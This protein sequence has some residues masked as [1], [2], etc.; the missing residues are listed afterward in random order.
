MPTATATMGRTSCGAER[1]RLQP[2]GPGWADGR[3][4]GPRVDAVRVFDEEPDLL[5]GIDERGAELLRRRAAAPRVWV[6]SGPWS[7]PAAD[8]R[9]GAS[10]GLLVIE[11]LM[12]RTVELEGHR[13]PELV[14]AGDVLRPWDE[15]DG[16]VS[17]ATSWT[18]LE[19]TSLAVLDEQFTAIV[20]RWPSIMVQLLSRSTQ[21]S[22]SLA[23]HFAIAH[24]RHAELR[25]HMLFWHLADRWGRMTPRGVHLPLRLT[26]EI[27]AQLAC[28][29]RPTASSAVNQL[30]RSGELARQPDGT[31]LLTGSP[32]TPAA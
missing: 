5:D 24:V 26:H 1:R 12:I 27:I 25:L 4:L 32:P 13:C 20:C 6:D 8:D 11:G 18:A 15:V 31:W 10:L 3:A 9:F 2:H 14:G 19:R 28:M 17:Y 29:R 30:A 7:P 22:R 16:S 23:F 21:R